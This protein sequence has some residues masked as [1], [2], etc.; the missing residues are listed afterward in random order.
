M[1]NTT[2]SVRGNLGHNVTAANEHVKTRV[3]ENLKLLIPKGVQAGVPQMNVINF[4]VAQ[5]CRETEVAKI[6]WLG[7]TTLASNICNLWNAGFLKP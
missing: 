7:V 1:D 6:D 4:T 5:L 2:I 3:I